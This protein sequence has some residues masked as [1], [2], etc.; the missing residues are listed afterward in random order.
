MFDLHK[1]YPFI[2]FTNTVRMGHPADAKVIPPN[3]QT[4][5]DPIEYKFNSMGFRGEDL[6]TPAEKKIMVVGCSFTYGDGLPWE[7]TWG[8]QFVEILKAQTGK[9]VKL[10]SVAYGGSGID[11][12]AISLMDALHSDFKPDVII[13]LLP[14]YSRRMIVERLD[15]EQF[16]TISM[17]L[18]TGGHGI[19]VM[20]SAYVGLNMSELDYINRSIAGIQMMYYT[21]KE[22]S[23][24][25]YTS[26]WS[27]DTTELLRMIPNLKNGILPV[28]LVCD[29]SSRNSKYYGDAA[30]KFKE[31]IARDLQH[32]GPRSHYVFAMEL[33]D[34]L[35]NKYD[36]KKAILS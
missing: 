4:Y 13:A 12:C 3:I 6:T 36:F 9:D 22:M 2:E 14:S 18:R 35:K 20:T 33:Y 17:I 16:D 30:V 8:Y 1:K 11:R 27:H 31:E 34:F 19:R 32:F 28:S 23:I 24:P 29:V 7:D 21:A 10:Y 26:S 5:T 15:G 25:L